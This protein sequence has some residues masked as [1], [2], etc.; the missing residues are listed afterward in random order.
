M[1]APLAT[2]VLALN[3][4][5][6]VREAIRAGRKADLKMRG[7]SL[8]VIVAVRRRNGW[9][10]LTVSVAMRSTTRPSVH[11]TKSPLLETNET[12]RFGHQHSSQQHTLMAFIV[13]LA[14]LMF[15]SNLSIVLRMIK[16]MKATIMDHECITKFACFAPFS[17]YSA[18][19]VKVGLCWLD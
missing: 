13:L 9:L 10:W 18:T 4:R 14:F 5:H 19:C 16:T 2:L 1:R 8:D 7:V 17:Y 15:T 12:F 6:C 3:E 11:V